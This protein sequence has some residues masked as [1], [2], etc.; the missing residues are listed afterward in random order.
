MPLWPPEAQQRDQVQADGDLPEQQ[1]E[2]L[3]DLPCHPAC[4]IKYFFQQNEAL[5]H[6]IEVTK[7]AVEKY[8]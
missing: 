4:Q 5:H 6:I 3:T 8:L 2:I 1:I 7:G